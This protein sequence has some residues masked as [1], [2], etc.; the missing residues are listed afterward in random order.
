[1][2]DPDVEATNSLV[3][4]LVKMP[5][6]ENVVLW[7]SV[8]NKLKVLPTMYDVFYADIFSSDNSA[9]ELKSC[10]VT[11]NSSV[12]SQTSQHGRAME[13]HLKCLQRKIVKFVTE[14]L[15]VLYPLHVPMDCW[16]HQKL[17]SDKLF[18]VSDCIFEKACVKAAGFSREL[19][20]AT[21]TLLLLPTASQIL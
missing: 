13:D 1:M 2:I 16:T 18:V 5:S 7:N 9:E 15:A 12:N 14:E 20:S 4:I 10:D 17:C 8:T 11:I 3:E 6:A 19:L 21:V